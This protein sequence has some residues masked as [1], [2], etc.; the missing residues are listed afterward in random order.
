MNQ[1]I[2]LRKQGL[3]CAAAKSAKVVVRQKIANIVS[4]VETLLIMPE[5]VSS[6]IPKKTGERCGQTGADH[7]SG[8]KNI[9]QAIAQS[10]RNRNYDDKIIGDSEDDFFYSSHLTPKTHQ[11]IA[12]LIGEKCVMECTLDNI[13]MTVLL[14]TGAQVSIISNSVLHDVFPD[15]KISDVSNILGVSQTLDLTTANGSDLPYVGF[16][17]LVFALPGASTDTIQVPFLVTEHDMENVIVG[18]NVVE[19]LVTQH[20]TPSDSFVASWVSSLNQVKAD[21]IATF[22]EVVEDAKK[23][24]PFPV[25][26]TKNRIAIPKNASVTVPCRIQIPAV[27][28]AT[29]FMFEPNDVET[30]PEG[31]QLHDK[32][33]TVKPTTSRIDIPVTNT[34]SQDITI[35]GRTVLGR[36][37]QVRSVAVVDVTKKNLPTSQPVADDISVKVSSVSS[38]CEANSAVINEVNLQGLTDDQKDVV[39]KM[40]HDVSSVFSKS[41]A[42]VGQIP[43]LQL[44]INL[45]DNIPVQKSYMNVPKPLFTEVKLYIEDL[46]NKNFIR[47]SKSPYSSPVECVRKK[48]GTLRLCIDYRALNKKTMPDRHPLPRIQQ[49]VENLGGNTLFSLLD[50]NKAYHQG[51]VSE[52]SRCKTAFITPWGLYKR[53]PFGLTNAPSVFQRFMEECLSDSGILRHCSGN[54]D[55]L[56]LPRKYRSLVI[57]ELH[58]NMGHLGTDRVFDLARERFHWPRMYTQIHEYVTKICPCLKDRRP[59]VHTRAPLQNITSTMPLELSQGKQP[60]HVVKPEDGIGRTRTIHRNLLLPCTLLQDFTDDTV[61]QQTGKGYT[62]CKRSQNRS[63][64]TPVDDDNQSD[65]EEFPSFTPAQLLHERNGIDSSS[66]SSESERPDTNERTPEPTTAQADDSNLSP[67]AEPYCSNSISRTATPQLNN[68]RPQ[69]T[70]HPPIMLN[71]GKFGSP[72][73]VQ[74]AGIYSLQGQHMLLNPWRQVNMKAPP[75]MYPYGAYHP[76]AY[77][78]IVPS[79]LNIAY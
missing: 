15:T 63:R 46:L 32:V 36:V 8:H 17:T 60:S 10:S 76:W 18:F 29:L 2:T 30:W 16:V 77:P 62:H 52:E 59:N 22:V 68:H 57:K 34:T 13:A 9:C 64:T 70:R 61:S 6:E 55:Q 72:S 78:C 26:A 38:E 3:T 33:V 45:T 25:K 28:K 44:D 31:V 66:V 51:Y 47:K 54:L 69:R 4:F 39:L 35:Q 67:F 19:E 50:M 42:D 40:L 49:T 73:N 5:V 11:K 43:E 65:T 41:D 58:N 71:Y 75:P 74:H 20:R 12:K 7:W 21:N 53:I 27:S 48:D 24:L 56:V 79:I 1:R 23:E 37:E 14:D